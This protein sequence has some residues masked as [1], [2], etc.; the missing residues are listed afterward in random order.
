M[1]ITTAEGF[2][3]A[4]E[5]SGLLEEG[6]LSEVRQMAFETPD[7]KSLAKGLV[8]KGL[9]SRW[10]AAQLLAGRTNVFFLGKYKLIEMLGRGGMGGVFL[11]HH[12]MMN[13]RVAL[14]V[15][16]KQIA[17][18]QAALEQFL[19]E[20]RAIAALD[21]PNIVRAYN[22]D[23]EEG[24][25]YLVMEY[26]EGKNLQQLVEEEGPLDFSKVADYIRQ[27]ADGLAHAHQHNLVH[28]DI[29]PANL[30]V[31]QE[32]VVKIL[33]LGLARLAAS[34]AE[35]EKQTD[36][37]IVGTVDYQAPEAAMGNQKVDGR[38]DIYSLGCTMFFLLTGK[39]PFG[40]GAL[41]ERI[42]K[43]QTQPPPDIASLRPG[44][45]KDLAA[46]CRKMMAKKPADRF[47][48]AEEL[49]KLLAR[50][51]PAQ[52]KLRKAVPLEESESPQTEPSPKA[53]SPIEQTDTAGS[54][55]TAKPAEKDLS[56]SKGTGAKGS[57]GTQLPAW[58]WIAGGAAA[59]VILGL[60]IALLVIFGTSSEPSTQAKAKKK[61][62][63]V[64][65]EEEESFKPP[66]PPSPG[67]QEKK[68]P[69]SSSSSGE[70]EK[71]S[72]EP[73][74]P[75][76][77][78][79]PKPS[80]EKPPEKP[81][82]KPEEKPAPK[83]EEKP[84]EQPKQEPTQPAPKSKDP[85]AAFK[86]TK[87]NLKPPVVDLPELDKTPSEPISKPLLKLPF[88]T[89]ARWDLQLIG[90]N[91]VFKSGQQFRMDRKRTDAG[92]QW[93]VFLEKVPQEKGEQPI[94]VA[95]LEYK[96][97]TRDLSFRWLPGAEPERANLFRNC[98]IDIFYRADTIPIYLRSP[99]ELPPLEFVPSK[100]FKPIP[101]EIAHLPGNPERILLHFL[102]AKV[103]EPPEW[104]NHKD[105]QK[106]ERLR[107]K[108]VF[109]PPKPTP[110]HTK[111]SFSLSF[112]WT[113]R[114]NNDHPGIVLQI[115]PQ[116]IGSRLRLDVRLKEPPLQVFRKKPPIDQAIALLDTADRAQ[117][118]LKKDQ[119]QDPKKRMPDKEREAV[120]QNMNQGDYQ[121]WLVKMLHVLDTG[122][123][124]HYQVLYDLTKYQVPVAHTASTATP[125]K[126]APKQ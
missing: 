8:Q 21:H 69:E 87:G 22:V 37:R 76:K 97:E 26:V 54:V 29:K 102:Q 72:S 57:V 78:P 110:L 89:D 44:T 77:Q 13:R 47:Q 60:A 113:D 66:I 98:V 9:L 124:I 107:Y 35:K 108:L 95:Q 125:P 116:L 114:A 49:S 101:Q 117:E 50:W 46:I 19:T 20:A 73:T 48:S 91:L 43:H 122:M 58:V 84:K 4:L 24:R 121:A 36:P 70:K 64:R 94:R 45:P 53:S 115:I 65:V 51:R 68:S 92:L 34:P 23:C 30:L 86:D 90:G 7:A 39:P 42:V 104:K 109:D 112:L 111:K 2:L 1:T 56:I 3:E 75:G 59:V 18:D 123:T 105:A 17:Q 6:Q 63:T 12:T 81:A 11:A 32:G 126:P 10:Q 62:L 74:P 67:S 118:Q 100:P 119:T 85:L 55:S 27:A 96:N 52:P 61:P 16:S 25:Y 41:H 83:P 5:K 79:P 80:E 82:P 38:A 88:E 28:C 33:D 14:K 99:I 15:V 93:E 106:L 103:E 31:T 71:P 40:E 120:R